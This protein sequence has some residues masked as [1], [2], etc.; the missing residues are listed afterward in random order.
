MEKSIIPANYKVIL[1]DRML[2]AIVVPQS[3]LD[4]LM[5]EQRIKI[6]IASV[7]TN[8]SAIW[9]NGFLRSFNTS[10]SSC[11]NIFFSAKIY[12]TSCSNCLSN[13]SRTNCSNLLHPSKAPVGC[14]LN[15]AT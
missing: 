12:N 4:G 6:L 10:C 13:Y 15:A 14:V 5:M 7:P 2:V 3:Y 9:F 8:C 11:F 1:G